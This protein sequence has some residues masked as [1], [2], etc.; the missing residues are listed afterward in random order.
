MVHQVHQEKAEHLV[1]QV[2]L[3]HLALQAVQVIAVPQVVQVHQAIQEQVVLQEPLVHV[4]QVVHQ[5]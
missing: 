1:L 4:E 2:F 3:P 5:E